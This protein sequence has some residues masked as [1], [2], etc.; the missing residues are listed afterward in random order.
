MKFNPNIIV[1]EELIKRV[2]KGIVG[3]PSRHGKVVHIPKYIVRIIINRF[4]HEINHA[5]LNLTPVTVRNFGLFRI[6]RTKARQGRN[7]FTK[8]L[9]IVP[10]MWRVT[11]RISETVKQLLKKKG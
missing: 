9:L 6:I 3:K 11:F 7:Q 2:T 5:L 8:K 10:P 4:L 1:K